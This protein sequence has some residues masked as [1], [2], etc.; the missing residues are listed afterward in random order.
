[1]QVQDQSSL[2]FLVSFF[3]NVQLRDLHADDNGSWTTSSPRRMY[4]VEKEG[5]SVVSVKSVT[6]HDNIPSHAE[7]YTLIRKYGIH[8][9]TLKFRRIISSV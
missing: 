2:M 7:R 9:E 4:S 1:M 3:A 8:K 5:N 6:S